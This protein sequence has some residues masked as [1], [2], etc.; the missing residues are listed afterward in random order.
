MNQDIIT[1]RIE[2]INLVL[3]Y[4]NEFDVQEGDSSE[5]TCTSNQDE[6]DEQE[7][8]TD[9][10]EFTIDNPSTSEPPHTDFD[11]DKAVEFYSQLSTIT[12]EITREALQTNLDN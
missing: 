5:F 3:K 12:L 2:A 4:R 11:F 10:S 7:K 8:T 6:I 1:K 9:P